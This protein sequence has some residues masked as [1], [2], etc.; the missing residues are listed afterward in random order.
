M[1]TRL[2]EVEE[3]IANDIEIW[4]LPFRQLVW[5]YQS[6]SAAQGFDSWLKKRISLEIERARL[7][8]CKK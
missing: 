8:E 3:M 6:E 4:Q 2:E 1:K 7:L 5:K